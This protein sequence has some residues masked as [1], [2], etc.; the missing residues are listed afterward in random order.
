M[1]N[2]RTMC[3]KVVDRQQRVSIGTNK[4]FVCVLMCTAATMINERTMCAKV[5]VCF[6]SNIAIDEMFVKLNIC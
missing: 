1:I 5:G 6:N 4:L 3:A 2:E